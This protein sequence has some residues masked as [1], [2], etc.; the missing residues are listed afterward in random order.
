MRRATTSYFAQ[1]DIQLL[2]KK[3][4][5]TVWLEIMDHDDPYSPISIHLPARDYE[6]FREAAKAFNT[7]IKETE[8]AK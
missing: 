1:S 2:V 5:L 6:R 4:N 8:V 3:E 7:I